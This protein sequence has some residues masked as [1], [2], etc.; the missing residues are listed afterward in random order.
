MLTPERFAELVAAL[1]YKKV[2]PEAVYLHKECLAASSPQLYR[3]VCAVAQALKLH[4]QEWDLVKLGK[5]EFRLSLLSYPTFFQDAYPILQQSVTVDLVKLSHTVIRYESQDNPPILHRKETMLAPDHPQAE[6][7]RQITEEG[8]LAGLYDRPRMI[9]FKASWERL[10]AKHG[11]QLVD[12]RLFRASAMPD[13]ETGPQIDRHK[14]A[15]VRHELSAPMKM[16]ARHGYL[17]G[18]Y[19]LFDYGCGRGDDLRELEAH[20]ID[21]LGWDPN[22]RPDGEKVASHLVNLG[23][24]I[25]VIE[26]HDERIDALLG[27]WELTQALLVVSAMLANETFIAQ[28]TPYKDG[29]ITSRNTF[30]RYYNQIE[31]KHYIDRT[32]DDNAIAVGPGIFY[33]FKDKL[34]EQRFLE[35]RQRRSHSWQQLTSPMIHHQATAALLIARH[36]PLFEAFWQRALTLGRIPAND[37]FEQGETLRAITGSHRKAMTMLGQHFDLAELKQAE[38]GAPTRSAGLSGPQPLWQ[39]ADLYPLPHRVAARY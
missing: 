19:G 29:V 27:A 21:A 10:I 36:Q 39:T 5:R 33:I 35:Q 37:E 11:Y 6:S 32:L 26:D 28:F 2:L 20:G 12:G 31:L 3:F 9:G 4:Q 15:L 1:P 25:N 23:F 18:D 16:L 7:C 17:N 22:F 30:Q 38:T 8:E 14:T 34:E 24:V 13:P